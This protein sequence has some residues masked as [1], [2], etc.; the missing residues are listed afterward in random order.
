M[1]VKGVF[2]ATAG[3]YDEARRR[4]IPCFDRFYGAALE[5]LPPGAERVL[6]LGAGTGLFSAMLRER[7]PG[8]ALH[9]VDVSEAMLAQAR[10]RFAG[11][12]RVTVKVRNYSAGALGTGWDVVASALS[13]HHLEHGA[14][15]ALFARV[16]EA[17][18]PGGWF[19]NADQV[20]GPT[21]ALEAEYVSRWLAAVRGAGATEMQIE[22]SLFRQREDRR[23]SAEA[24]MGWM[25]EAG[26][27]AVDCW[28]KEGSFA[29]FVAN[30]PGIEP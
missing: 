16:L 21:E 26:F 9:L 28:F 2:D 23:A 20:A 6:E 7:M 5:L 11:D 19:V 30:R 17:L 13:I 27:E 29:V 18:R 12:A 10:E 24:Q 22:E 4:L 8:A 1:S 25:R 14:K 3:T 15:Q